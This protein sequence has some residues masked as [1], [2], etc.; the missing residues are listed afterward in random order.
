MITLAQ[1]RENR[2][3]AIQTG[4]KVFEGRPCKHG[5]TT[6][7]VNM[8][9]C[10]TCINTKSTI[11]QKQNPDKVS[12]ASKRWRTKNPDKHKQVYRDWVRTPEGK[13][14]KRAS[15]AKRRAARIQATPPWLTQQDHAE[16][17]LFYSN[18]P[19]GYEVDHII[20]LQGEF[21]SGLHVLSNLQ[22]LP[23][24]ENRSKHNRW[25]D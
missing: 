25:S 15:T 10:V 9:G 3:L 20:P 7:Y 5:H 18:C 1:S 22:Y 24:A 12:E 6:R 11:R 8:N 23:M 19:E 2:Q 16:I 21:I 4:Q 14:L 13:L 17:K